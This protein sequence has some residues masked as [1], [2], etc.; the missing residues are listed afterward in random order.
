[1]HPNSFRTV[2]GRSLLGV[3]LDESA[4]FRD[5]TSALPDVETYRAVMPALASNAGMLIGISSPYRRTG[6]LYAKH[7]DHFGIDGD[8]VLVL[9]ASSVTLNPT[10]D[11][12]IIDQA[13]AADPAAAASEWD[14]EFRS[15]LSQFV[16]D[17]AIDA[18]V[19]HARP[20]ELPY[21][22]GTRYFAFC[23]PSAGRNDHF[24]I[25]I[26]HREGDGFV[27]DALRGRGAPC[28]PSAAAAEFASLCK[29][30]HVTTIVGDNFSGEWVAAA[31]RKHG[32]DYRRSKQ[33]RSILY[34]ESMA[35]FVSGRV[36][37][38]DHSRVLRE[39]RL[40]ERKTAPSGKDSI[41][42]PKGGSDA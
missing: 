9:Q 14:A 3:V 13:R 7:R 27:C 30:Y 20:V 11:R 26:G 16:S 35:P 38:P 19:N 25:A 12:K 15:D 31:F 29:Q 41:D 23:D 21:Q 1:V 42:H 18:T 33:P 5:E 34:L 32:I 8:D 4:Y 28:D 2:R 17:E 24:T 10:I 22:S 6:L 36:S 39:L 37:L 40:L